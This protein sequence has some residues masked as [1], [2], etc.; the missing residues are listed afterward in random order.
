M[1]LPVNP[2]INKLFNVQSNTSPLIGKGQLVIFNYLGYKND[3]YPMVIITDMIPGRRLRGVN[4]HYLTY[5][6]IQNLISQNCSNPGFSYGAIRGD[7]FVVNAFRS[8]KWQSIRQMKKLDCNF[9]QAV[10]NVIRGMDPNQVHAMR[11]SVREQISRQ[12][13]PTPDQLPQAQPPQGTPNI[14]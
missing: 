3:P 12:V 4:L 9:L 14:T 1:P 10:I 6:Y 7:S 13:N 2:N 5:N 11:E 8:Y